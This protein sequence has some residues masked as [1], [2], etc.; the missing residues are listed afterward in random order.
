MVTIN[1]AISG[2]LAILVGLL[3]LIVP[4]LLRW[5]I[6]LYLIIVGILSFIPM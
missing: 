4:R 5:A 6:G 1:L 3:I 2:I